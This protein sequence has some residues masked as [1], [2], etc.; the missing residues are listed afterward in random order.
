M[1]PAAARARGPHVGDPPDWWTGT[2][3]DEFTPIYMG[4]AQ[5]SVL[6]RGFT[7]GDVDRMDLVTIWALMGV[8]HQQRI[9]E[10]RVEP[11][12]AAQDEAVMSPLT[13][14]EKAERYAARRAAEAARV[15]SGRQSRV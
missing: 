2:V 11:Y 8:K 6:H 14:E 1:T 7:P 13:A 15:R 9:I 10:S 3:E 12:R 5:P 4:M